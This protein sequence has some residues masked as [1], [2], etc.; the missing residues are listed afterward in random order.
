MTRTVILVIVFHLG[1]RSSLVF[2][3]KVA[4]AFYFGNQGC[5]GGAPVGSPKM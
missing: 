2:Q 1:P 4:R 5:P 3:V